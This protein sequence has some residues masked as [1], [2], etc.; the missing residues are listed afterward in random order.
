MGEGVERK[1]RR[2]IKEGGEEESEE[3]WKEEKEVTRRGEERDEGWR[4]REGG[5]KEREERR[6]R[7]GGEERWR[8]FWLLEYL[9]R[10][11]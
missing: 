9:F 7:S 3:G 11:N 8:K 10:Y 6:E 5:V 2:G 4:D 1:R